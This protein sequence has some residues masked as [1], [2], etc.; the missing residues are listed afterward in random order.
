MDDI[1]WLICRFV[2]ERKF[3]FAKSLMGTMQ[4]GGKRER[5]IFE[6]YNW[7]CRDNRLRFSFLK[8]KAYLYFYSIILTVFF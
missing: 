7:Y 2:E 4:D 5:D 3:L 1:D 6:S 8:F